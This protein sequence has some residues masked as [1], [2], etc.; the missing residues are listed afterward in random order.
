MPL[1]IVPFCLVFNREGRFALISEQTCLLG[2][3]ESERRGSGDRNLGFGGPGAVVSARAWEGRGSLG[4]VSSLVRR[5]V[6]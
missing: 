4:G 3:G 6:V 5:L 2:N 1:R